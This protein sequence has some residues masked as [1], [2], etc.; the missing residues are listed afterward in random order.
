MNNVIDMFARKQNSSSSPSHSERQLVQLSSEQI[1]EEV[2][3]RNKEA[4][5]KR[6]KE[7]VLHNNKV[8]WSLSKKG[9]KR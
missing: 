6:A 8:I 1:F 9:N 4:K 2:A 7:R 3:K 5:A